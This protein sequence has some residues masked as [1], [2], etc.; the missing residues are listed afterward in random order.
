MPISIPITGTNAEKVAAV[1]GFMQSDPNWQLV[2][3]YSEIFQQAWQEELQSLV[4]AGYVVDVHWDDRVGW[5]IQ[6]HIPT[7]E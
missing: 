5:R 6:V 3:G 4:P 1:R 7:G 2:T